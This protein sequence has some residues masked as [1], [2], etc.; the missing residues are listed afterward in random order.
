[1]KAKRERNL[2][3]I[4]DR[5]YFDFSLAGKRY[6]RLGGRTKEEARDAMARLRVE[7]LEGPKGGAADVEDP[8]FK[9]FAKEYIELYAKPNKRS[10]ERDERSIAHLEKSFGGRRLSQISLLQVERYRVAR[11]DQVSL[12]TV[13]RELACLKGIL[14]KAIDWEKLPTFPLRKIKI[15]LSQEQRRERIL[16]LDEE[17][18]LLSAAAPHLRPMIVLAL[19][20]GMRRGEV[21]KL[22]TESVDLRTRFITIPKENSKSKKPR[23][24]PMDSVA[25]ELLER[26]FPS[27]PGFIFHKSDGR[28]YKNICEAF[29]SACR[30]ARKDPTD[31]RDK[32]IQDLRF[33][34]L[35][36]TFE[37]RGVER[38]MNLAN[39]R[40]IMGHSSIDFSLS[41]YYHADAAR[42]LDDV[43][44][45]ATLPAEHERQHERLPN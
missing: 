42:L 32:G 41:H 16:T 33:H 40:D 24:I 1:M 20:T 37:T 30:R 2:K 35:R 38:G 8:L 22:R 25:L 11:L 12:A 5:W 34:D 3:Q 15:D 26:L 45:L 17:G 44:K 13:H 4:G 6:I 36:H 43:E 19:H 27:D 9:D 28:P 39:M 14:S 10:W 29:Q 18:R 23:K 21:L 31:P 7:L